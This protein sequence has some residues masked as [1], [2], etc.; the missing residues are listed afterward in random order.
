MVG[1]PDLLAVAAKWSASHVDLAREQQFWGTGNTALVLRMLS[2][3]EELFVF[4]E[5]G[6][7]IVILL[8]SSLQW[9]VGNFFLN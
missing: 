6:H 9:R 1:L 4:V 2:S 5:T 3:V 8:Q 7:K